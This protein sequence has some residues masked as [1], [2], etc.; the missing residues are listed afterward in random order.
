M[1]NHVRGLG[2]FFQLLYLQSH[3]KELNRA[4]LRLHLRFVLMFCLFIKNKQKAEVVQEIDVDD[5]L[6][7]MTS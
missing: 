1:L 6:D 5:F 4:F 2:L 7:G 3:Q